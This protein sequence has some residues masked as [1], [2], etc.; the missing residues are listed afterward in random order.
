[1]DYSKHQIARSAQLQQLAPPSESADSTP[2]TVE[3]PPSEASP[4]QLPMLAQS[5]QSV[6][7]FP[8][9]G[10]PG[11][12]WTRVAAVNRNNFSKPTSGIPLIWPCS[13]PL[14]RIVTQLHA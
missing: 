3:Y 14:G 1:M 8:A 2:Y 4:Y 5:Q 13:G 10:A 7:S 9:L 6:A 12:A 11:Q